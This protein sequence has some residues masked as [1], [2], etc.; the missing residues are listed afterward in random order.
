MQKKKRNNKPVRVNNFWSNNYIE[1]ESNGDMNKTLSDKKYLNKVRP[2]LKGIINNLKKFGTLKIQLTII[3]F[4][5]FLD[6]DKERVMHS[7]CDTQKS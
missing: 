3:N 6:N 2:Y 7:K 4:I 1:Y 5:S